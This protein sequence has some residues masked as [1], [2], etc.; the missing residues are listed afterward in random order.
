MITIPVSTI[1]TIQSRHATDNIMD[2]NKNEGDYIDP[3][4]IHIAQNTFNH[5]A[6]NIMDKN[7]NEGDFIN[8]WGVYIAK[9]TLPWGRASG[10]GETGVSM[11][12]DDTIGLQAWSVIVSS[13]SSTIDSNWAS[14]GTN[15]HLGDDTGEAVANAD[16][17]TQ[18]RTGEDRGK[19]EKNIDGNDNHVSIVAI[20]PVTPPMQKD[21]WDCMDVDSH[22]G[23]RNKDV[24]IDSMEQGLGNTRLRMNGSGNAGNNASPVIAT[25]PPS[26]ALSIPP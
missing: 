17:K 15:Y 21:G 5:A 22:D 24:G 19:A 12:G 18:Q 8:P 9:K 3:W 13:T 10:W 2:K 20:T 16:T 23:K 7:K 4:G 1:N 14:I 26:I 6:N 11:G 25:L